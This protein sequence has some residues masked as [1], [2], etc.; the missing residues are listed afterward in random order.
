M[1]VQLALAVKSYLLTYWYGF[2]FT[3]QIP[4]RCISVVVTRHIVYH[5]LSHLLDTVCLMTMFTLLNSFLVS[6]LISYEFC[7]RHVFSVY[8]YA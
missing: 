2:H 6:G 3:S 8:F 1:I 7:F 5:H 4:L